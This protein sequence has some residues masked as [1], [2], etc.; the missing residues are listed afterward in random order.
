MERWTGL[1]ALGAVLLVA[2]GVFLFVPVV[3]DGP[4]AVTA[5]AIVNGQPV[6]YFLVENISGY[7]ISGSIPVSVSWS[8]DVTLYQSWLICS[9]HDYDRVPQEAFSRNVSDCRSG[10]GDPASGA[11]SWTVAGNVPNGGSIIVAFGTVQFG[12][13]A[14]NITYT[15]WTGLT[16]ASTALFA[17]G[18]VSIG[19]GVFIFMRAT[20]S[21]TSESKPE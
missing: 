16:L 9:N 15:V 18:L 6:G 5:P 14:M 11:T 13:H 2:G 21:E 17:A 3:P 4:H 12:P 1:W 8:S 10:G 19:L 20:R 7:S